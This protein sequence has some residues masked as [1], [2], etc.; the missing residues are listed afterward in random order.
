MLFPVVKRIATKKILQQKIKLFLQQ[1]K[2]KLFR[3]FA[4]IVFMRCIHQIRKQL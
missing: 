1:Q 2:I 4:I 3:I